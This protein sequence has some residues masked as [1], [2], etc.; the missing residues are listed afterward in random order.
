MNF[1]DIQFS[2]C[3]SR[4][5]VPSIPSGWAEDT[6]PCATFR[7]GPVWGY[8]ERA[9]VG[10]APRWCTSDAGWRSNLFLL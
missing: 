5:H 9:L 7:T 8:R 3:G 4:L 10:S 6:Q 1:G 2:M